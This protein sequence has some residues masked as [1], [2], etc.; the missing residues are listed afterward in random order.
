MKMPLR[1]RSFAAVRLAL[2]LVFV[3]VAAANAYTGDMKIFQRHYKPRSPALK[4]CSVCHLPDDDTKLNAY[5]RDWLA[6]GGGEMGLQ[7]IEGKDSD[8]DGYS[9]MYEIRDGSSPGLKDSIPQTGRPDKPLREG[10]R[11][12]DDVPGPVIIDDDEEEPGA[13]DEGV[14]PPG[15]GPGVGP[16]RVAPGAADEVPPIGPDLGPRPVGPGGV[17]D[18]TPIDPPIGP[19]PGPGIGPTPVDPDIQPVV[20][21]IG[22]DIGPAP[23]AGTLGTPN[24]PILYSA[25]D[26]PGSYE[27]HLI[28]GGQDTVISQGMEDIERFGWS[29]GGGYAWFVGRP[30]TT[31]G[32]QPAPKALYVLVNGQP[33][34][35]SGDILVD[36]RSV[37]W[38]PDDSMV[39]FLPL[40]PPGPAVLYGATLPD[41]QLHELARLVTG[42]FSGV[43]IAPGP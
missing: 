21:P 9:N 5:G 18:P 17:V 22:P 8:R 30:A 20:T 16:G 14:T 7:E 26:L 19:G 15:I 1:E 38:L 23:V 3:A 6:I 10:F 37:A 33:M 36:Y 2:L 39:L 31:P 28:D 29:A 40:N 12:R 42:R 24:Y 43:D 11:P 27:L 25:S 32:A 41:C 4:Q 34:N 35:V 13:G